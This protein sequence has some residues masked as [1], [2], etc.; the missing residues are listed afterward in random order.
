MGTS[1][2][3]KIKK[4]WGRKASLCLFRKWNCSGA[5]M[6]ICQDII[7]RKE[8]TLLKAITGLE[9]GI[10]SSGSTCGVVSGGALGLAL[11][12]DEALQKNGIEAEVGLISLAGQYVKWFRDE[13]GTTLCR[14]RS[15]VDFWS[16]GGLTRY[17]LP[18]DRVLRCLAHISKSMQ[19]VYDN[20]DQDLPRI[21]VE[22]VDRE[23][24]PI[25]CAQAVL[26]S[27]RANTTIGDP[28]L[29]RL[30]VVLDGGV[31]LQGGACG[32]L[33]G[34]IMEINI[35]VGMNLRDATF[36]EAVKAFFGGHKNLRANKPKEIPEPYN[37]GKEV[38][39]KFKEEAGAIECRTITGKD[40]SDWRSFQEYM[41][42]SDKC[43][44][45]IELSINEATKAIERHI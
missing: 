15:G 30:S 25:H 17:L 1:T 45:L 39:R 22:Q 18:G 41:C 4:S 12:H 8:D 42:S 5:T 40:F 31:G 27:V 7:S 3:D 26:K 35:L 21:E 11:M 20:R 16:L 9:G 10:V 37:V 33:A 36:M 38:V 44:K 14:E 28:I 19:Y 43:Q 34:A 23:A 24:A 6:Q 32:A 13:Y 2:N 29:E